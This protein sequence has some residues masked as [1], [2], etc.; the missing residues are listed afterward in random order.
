MLFLGNSKA[1]R[2]T[3][4]RRVSMMM[5][6]VFVETCRWH[7]FNQAGMAKVNN[8]NSRNKQTATPKGMAVVVEAVITVVYVGL[9]ETVTQPTKLRSLI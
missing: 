9:H 2:K 8:H 6:T 3:R 5:Q 7:V 1:K 4:Q